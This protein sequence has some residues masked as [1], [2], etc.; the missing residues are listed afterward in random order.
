MYE[1]PYFFNLPALWSDF[2]TRS[3]TGLMKWYYLAQFAFWLQQIVVVNIE[4]KRKDH[5]QM[6]THH[7]ITCALMLF[8]YGY[9]QTK[10]GNTI[11]C[12]MDA[13]DLILPVRQA[14][15][16]FPFS[17]RANTDDFIYRQPSSSSTL[18]TN[19]CATSLLSSSLQPGS[20]PA[21]SSTS[22]C[23]GP[24]TSMC[25]RLCTMAATTP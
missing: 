19:P 16:F 13:V 24:S 8:S 15:I 21:T 14:H 22:P 2:P 7:I 25:H 12:L 11:L 4:E 9:Y 6:F 20:S 10:V 3:M 17:Q 1:T 23:A 18:A 5:W